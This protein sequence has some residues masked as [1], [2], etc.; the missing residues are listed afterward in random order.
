MINFYREYTEIS[1]KRNEV[2]GFGVLTSLYI[3]LAEGKG[4]NVT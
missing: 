3:R 2:S 1:P 4:W